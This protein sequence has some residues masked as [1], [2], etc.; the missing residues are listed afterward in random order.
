MDDARSDEDLIEQVIGGDESGLES[1][2]DRYARPVYSL[3]LQMV[4]DQQVAE[5]L[6][7]EVFLRV[8]RADS[9]CADKGRPMS[10]ILGIAHHLAVDELRRRSARPRLVHDD[11]QV[12]RSLLEVADASPDPHELTLQGIRR[13]QISEALA[14]LPASQREVLVLAYFGG[15]T[16]SEIAETYGLPLGT[17][18]TRT[19]LALGK[20]RVYLE[21]GG[22]DWEAL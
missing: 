3:M 19:R 16:Q 17:V 5:E 14:G 21:A 20:L 7:Q 13:R 10:W 9:Y 6:T 18:K 4:S 15:L 8:W 2:Y 1:L 11:P 12:G 22:A